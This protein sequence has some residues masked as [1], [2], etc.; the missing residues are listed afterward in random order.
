MAI[1]VH[2]AEHAAYTLS[3]LV[4]D[5]PRR[6]RIDNATPR[7]ERAIRQLLTHP[8]V[9][10]EADLIVVCVRAPSWTERAAETVARWTGASAPERRYRPGR[11]KS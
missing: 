11:S 7:F 8:P 4:D 10:G 6:V 2:L 1:V 9:Q 3:S 5:L